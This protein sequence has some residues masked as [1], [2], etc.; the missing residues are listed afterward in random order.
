MAEHCGASKLYDAPAIY[1]QITSRELFCNYA[2]NCSLE[3]LMIRYGHYATEGPTQSHDLMKTTVPFKFHFP[4]GKKCSSP[5]QLSK[6][7][8]SSNKSFRWVFGGPAVS[9]FFVD[10]FTWKYLVTTF[11]HACIFSRPF[12]IRPMH[13]PLILSALTLLNRLGQN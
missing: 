5:Q 4:L 1:L 12:D 10:V 9:N 6:F 2:K 13:E 7:L 11:F 8:H 3:Q